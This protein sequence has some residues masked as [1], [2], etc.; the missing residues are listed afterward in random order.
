MSLL[1]KHLECPRLQNIEWLY[2]PVSFSW[3]NRSSDPLRITHICHDRLSQ[4]L[5]VGK[6]NFGLG[7]FASSRCE[8]CWPNRASNLGLP[9]NLDI[10]AE[11]VA[12]LTTMVA[13]PVGVAQDATPNARTTVRKAQSQLASIGQMQN[14]PH[15]ARRLRN[16]KLCFTSALIPFTHGFNQNRG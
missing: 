16:S 14:R 13:F 6:I 10:A 9:G 4:Y 2:I 15:N 12:S 11:S 8:V 1:A 7:R 5:P 3:V